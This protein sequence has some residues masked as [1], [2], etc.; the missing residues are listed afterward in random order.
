MIDKEKTVSL[1]GNR[2]L[3]SDFEKDKV[4][5][6]FE[7][8]IKKGFNT[9]L[10]GMAVGFDTECFLILKKLREI[11]PINIYACVPCKDQDKSF[12]E[13]EKNIYQ[14]L[15]KDS[16]EVILLSEHY[17]KG[18]MIVR[19]KYMVDNSLVLVCYNRKV[20]GGTFY[21]VNYAKKRGLE[22]IEL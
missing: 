21:T 12:S 19:N 16:D 17:Y 4:L 6:V 20:S 8:L 9:F 10:C 14:K 15:I 5:F 7:N 11:Y 22:I 18:C 13:K 2:Q 1:S 3:L